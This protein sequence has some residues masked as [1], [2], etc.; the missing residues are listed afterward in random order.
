MS[1]MNRKLTYQSPSI[2]E[3]GIAPISPMSNHKKMFQRKQ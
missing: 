3:Y 1:K 2:K